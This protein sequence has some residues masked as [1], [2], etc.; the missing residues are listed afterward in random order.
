MELQY[1]LRAH[2][3]FCVLIT[4]PTDRY[5]VSQQSDATVRLAF[6]TVAF[7]ELHTSH[8]YVKLSMTAAKLTDTTLLIMI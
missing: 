2:G 8:A 5:I 7:G 6:N 1:V 3:C 4:Y